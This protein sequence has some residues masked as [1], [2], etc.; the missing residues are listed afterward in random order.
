MSKDSNLISYAHK[1]ALN[2]GLKKDIDVIVD[3]LHGF[4]H[5]IQTRFSHKIRL[6]NSNESSLRHELGHAYMAEKLSNIY[7]F[8]DFFSRPFNFLARKYGEIGEFASN[9]IYSMVVGVPILVGVLFAQNNGSIEISLSLILIG[10]S[11]SFPLMDEILAIY[12]GE[13]FKPK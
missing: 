4:N 6:V 11:L 8:F 9:L 10:I 5:Y 2:M 13:K 12:F 1:E 7:T 3:P